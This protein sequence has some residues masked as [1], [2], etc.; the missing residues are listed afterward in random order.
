MIEFK[1][2]D[3]H[4]EFTKRCNNQVITLSNN[5]HDYVS[6]MYSLY[7][8]LLDDN[9]NYLV[10]YNIKLHD[11]IK[12][13]I[14]G[15]RINNKPRSLDEE[16]FINDYNKLLSTIESIH[17]L[18]TQINLYSFLNKIPYSIFR[19]IIN[20][21]NYEISVSLLKGET[22]YYPK[23]GYIYIGRVP[24]DDS[25]PDWGNSYKFRDFLQGQGVEAKSKSNP[26]GKNWLVGNGLNRDD[27]V[28]FRWKKSSSPL[29]NKEPY[30]FFPSVRGNIYGKKLTRPF[31]L[32][33]LFENTSTGLFDK[34]I[35]IYK[36]HYEYST[37]TYPFVKTAKEKNETDNEINL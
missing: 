29:R 34:I 32:Q 20:S 17:K 33:E 7:Y 4:N 31:T 11:I 9:Y 21:I 22:Y 19:I 6:L 30:R 25:I 15:S 18:S 37:N 1:E 3:F 23:V 10:K 12:T 28:L 26:D 14:K 13:E 5:I 2:V 27:F 36:Y 8:K 16:D 35:H 24:Y